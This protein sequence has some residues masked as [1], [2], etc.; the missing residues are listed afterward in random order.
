MILGSTWGVLAD[1]AATVLEGETTCPWWGYMIGDPTRVYYSLD[2]S[3]TG[4]WRYGWDCFRRKE[5]D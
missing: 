2:R 1:T 4:G 5:L 3:Y